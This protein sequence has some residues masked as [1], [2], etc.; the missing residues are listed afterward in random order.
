M[1]KLNE[2]K[3]TVNEAG[4]QKLEELAMAQT[5]AEEGVRNIRRSDMQMI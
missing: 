5:K 2:L 4:K 3:E 1:M